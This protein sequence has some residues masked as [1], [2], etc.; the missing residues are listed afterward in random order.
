V[1]YYSNFFEVDYLTDSTADIVVTKLKAHFAR[2]GIPD[3][4]VSDNGPQF[5]AFKFKEFSQKWGFTH[6]T[7]A[8]GNSRANGA[9]EAAVKI[10]KRVMKRSVRAG[11]DPYLGLLNQ[12]NTPTESV[13]SSP[14]QRLFGRRT[15]SDIPMTQSLLKP[16]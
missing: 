14:V 10:A 15:K 7:S 12:R 8:P 2:H 9:A 11:E 3:T 16:T 6:V 1:D 13:G 5:S 4:L